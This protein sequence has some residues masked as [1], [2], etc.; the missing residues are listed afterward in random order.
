VEIILVYFKNI[1]KTK[2]SV[3]YRTKIFRADCYI[4]RDRYIKSDIFRNTRGNKEKKEEK[5]GMTTEK[6]Q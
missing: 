4:K 2:Y 3:S 6:Y 5:D 1:L